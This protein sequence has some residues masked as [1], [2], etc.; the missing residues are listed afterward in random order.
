MTSGTTV[1]HDDRTRRSAFT[2][3]EMLVV[4]FVIAILISILLPAL[5]RA[6]EQAKEV[7]CK[8]NLAGFGKGFQMYAEDNRDYMCSGSFDADVSNG[9]DGPVDRVG[10]VADLVNSNLGIPANQICPSNSALYNQKLGKDPDTGKSIYTDE[11]ATELVKRGYNSN[12][13]QVWYMARSGWKAPRGRATSAALNFRRVDSTIGPIRTTS[14]LK[15][16][17][18]RVPLLGD[19][20]TDGDDLVLGERA[21]KTMSD[22]PWGGPYGI[23]NFADIGPAHGSDS[24]IPGKKGHNKIR[25]NVLFGDGHVDAFKDLDRDGEFG[26]NDEGDQAQQRDLDPTK[27]FDGVLA[28]GRRSQNPRKME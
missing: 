9:R 8:A 28:E 7:Q 24:W 15:V 11:Q 23:Q 22:G 19:G 21:V 10:W 14:M 3:L 4:M 25:A 6:R 20:R 16:S 5:H 26:I 18:G 13:T 1:R 27:V 17:A 12:Y 2:L